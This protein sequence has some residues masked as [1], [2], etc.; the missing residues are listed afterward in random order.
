[1][2]PWSCRENGNIKCIR[3]VGNISNVNGNENMEE[4]KILN[5]GKTGNLEYVK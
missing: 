4:D 2:V 3:K 1:M 5:L